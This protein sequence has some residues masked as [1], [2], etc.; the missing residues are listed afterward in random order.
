MEEVSVKLGIAARAC[1]C[2]GCPKADA[3]SAPPLA[4]PACGG[5]TAKSGGAGDNCLCGHLCN[6]DWDAELTQCNGV[7]PLR[8]C[9]ECRCVLP[10]WGSAF[11]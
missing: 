7:R 9:Y 1:S 2:D 6:V 8:P 11:Y 3:I 4:Q 10:S 5:Y